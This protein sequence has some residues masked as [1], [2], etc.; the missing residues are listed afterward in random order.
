MET[1]SCAKCNHEIG[2]RYDSHLAVADAD[3]KAFDPQTD[4][5]RD[6]ELISDEGKIAVQIGMTRRGFTVAMIKNQSNP[7]VLH[8]FMQQLDA[9]PEK[10]DFKLRWQPS[11][12]SRIIVGLWHSAFL[13]MFYNFGY[14]FAFSDFAEKMRAPLLSDLPPVEPLF[15]A[16]P[17]KQND[18][19]AA[20]LLNHVSVISVEGTKCFAIGIP[21]REPGLVGRLLVIPGPDRKSQMDFA[22]MMAEKKAG[23]LDVSCAQVHGKPEERLGKFAF[24]Q[25]LNEAWTHQ[26][27]D[28]M[29]LHETMCVLFMMTAG[30]TT[31]DAPIKDLAENLGLNL[32]HVDYLVRELASGGWVD[33][34]SDGTNIRLTKNGA[35]RVV[36]IGAVVPIREAPVLQPKRA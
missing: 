30:A 11:D 8:N 22:S 25:F 3:R 16:A 15:G 19:F 28:Q 17:L 13:M 35:A 33:R 36:E 9:R 2:S 34:G 1:L 12:P 23:R 26:G 14:E 20:N 27:F 21:T 7:T 5:L 29:F 4:D 31:I 24:R 10:I 6:A 18:E 32:D